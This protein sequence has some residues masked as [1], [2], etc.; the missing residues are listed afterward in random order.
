M[1]MHWIFS[2]LPWLAVTAA[3]TVPVPATAQFTC[4]APTSNVWLKQGRSSDRA[5]HLS[6]DRIRPVSQ[7]LPRAIAKLATRSAVPLSIPEFQA[8]TGSASPTNLGHRL[9]PYLVRAVFST[10]N[11]Q[12]DVWWDGKTLDVNA[13]GLGCAPFLKHPVVVFLD[14][15]P[16]Q[17]F[18]AASAAL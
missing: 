17:V 15:Q 2:S 5:E 11:P 8:F 10:T 6:P 9:R 7:A 4:K 16:R 12:L 14:R 3:I 13:D 18:V 1:T